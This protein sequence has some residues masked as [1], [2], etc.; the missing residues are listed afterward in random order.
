MIT[1]TFRVNDSFLGYPA[2][3]ITVPRSQV[4]YNKVREL[5]SGSDKV[6]I[7]VPHGAT[8]PGAIYHGRAGYGPYYQVRFNAPIPV[9]EA[10]LEK[11]ELVKVMI[12]QVEGR[13]EVQIRR[14]S[15]SRPSAA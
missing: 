4:E 9:S 7:T 15:T 2:H 11:D 8:V 3:P 5:L 13:V 10:G 12:F 14:Q 6:W 1:F